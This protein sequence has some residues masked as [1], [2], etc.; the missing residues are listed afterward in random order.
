[1]NPRKACSFAAVGTVD[2]IVVVV[3]GHGTFVVVVVVAA[4][5]DDDDDGIVGF[6]VAAP[7]GEFI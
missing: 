6:G 3:K 4:V 1:M 5:V 2:I 7:A